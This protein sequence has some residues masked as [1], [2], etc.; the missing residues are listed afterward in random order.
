MAK[1]LTLIP[2]YENKRQQTQKVKIPSQAI[3]IN[4]IPNDVEHVADEFID[5]INK[6]KPMK[7][8]KHNIWQK[9]P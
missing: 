3:K 1:L 9:K 6:A 4:S 2:K 7:N 8:I 5:Q